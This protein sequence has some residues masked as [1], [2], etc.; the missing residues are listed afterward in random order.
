MTLRTELKQRN[1][2]A[3]SLAHGATGIL[4]SRPLPNGSE[5]NQMIAILPRY[6]ATGGQLIL[7]DGPAEILPGVWV[8]GP[9]PRKFPEHNWS[10][11]SNVRTPIAFSMASR[12]VLV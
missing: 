4:Y 5:D 11:S 6:Q 1:S 7:H 12:S 8:T 2:G 9:I 10:G 3:L